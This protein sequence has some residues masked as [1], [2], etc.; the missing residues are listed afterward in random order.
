M[1]LV[2]LFGFVMAAHAAVFMFVFAIPGCRSSNK[3]SAAVASAPEVSPIGSAEPSGSP[4]VSES[5]AAEP[6]AIRFS[7]TRPGTA[8]AAVV[9]SAPAA[10]VSSDYVVV[11]G[12]TLWGIAKKN[13]VSVKQIAAVNNIRSDAPLKLGQKL[14]IPGKAA[15]TTPAATTRAAAASSAAVAVPAAKT[16]TFTHV[17]KAGD[18]LGGIAK[19]YQVK[20]GDIA[21]ANN[22]ADPTKIRIGQTLKIPGWQ[23]PAAKSASSTVFTPA[24]APTVAPAAPAVIESPVIGSP[25]LD[26]APAAN[27]SP[28]TVP[29]SGFQ[30]APVIRIE[31]SGAPR[32]E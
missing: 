20:L 10:S 30:D 3:K 32:I 22:I 8:A 4:F 25:F 18:T 9:E 7:P 19:K 6:A 31:E 12:D 27:E 2:K 21:A 17:V 26:P 11:K 16:G 28:V 13:G 5:N 24:P 14:I 1:K 15:A 23:Q 29:S